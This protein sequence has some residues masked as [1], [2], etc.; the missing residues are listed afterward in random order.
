MDNQVESEKNLSLQALRGLAFLGIFFVH[1]RAPVSWATLGV[2]TFFV[3]SGCLLYYRNG[4][5]G[6][7][8]SLKTN[9]L[10][11]RKKMKKL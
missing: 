10:F 2:S 3:L 9:M 11:A 5:Q 4:K 7:P 6:L 1:T 8:C